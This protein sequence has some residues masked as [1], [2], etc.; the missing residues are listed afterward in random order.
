MKISRC[1]SRCNSMIPIEGSSIS[2]VRSLPPDLVHWTNALRPMSMPADN[3]TTATLISYFRAAASPATI[4]GNP[5][6]AAGAVD[7]FC[8]SWS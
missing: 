2:F 6:L 5:A 7:A 8:F 1:L 3:G 4:A